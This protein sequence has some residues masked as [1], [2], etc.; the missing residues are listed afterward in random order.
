M[1]T[2]LIDSNDENSFL[3]SPDRTV[4]S[5]VFLIVEREKERDVN[6][7]V[8]TALVTADRALLWTDG[9]YFL[10]AEQELDPQ[11]WTLMKE[12]NKDVLS[13]NNWLSK[14]RRMSKER[15]TKDAS[16]RVEFVEEQFDWC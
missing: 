2:S 5:I 1:N 14:V 12:G 13:I 11:H 6:V 7:S 16:R 15:E 3:N 8:G 9:R 10:Q 4:R